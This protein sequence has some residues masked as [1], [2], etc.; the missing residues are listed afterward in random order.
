MRDYYLGELILDKGRFG[1]Y[2][3]Q[4]GFFHAGA[5]YPFDGEE[6]DR[7]EA[8]ALYQGNTCTNPE[9]NQ[10]A[11]GCLLCDHLSFYEVNGKEFVL[12]KEY[13]SNT[14]K[15]RYPGQ[16]VIQDDCTINYTWAQGTVTYCYMLFSGKTYSENNSAAGGCYIVVF[17]W[18]GNH[19]RTLETDREI[20]TFCVDEP[21]RMIYATALDD[22]GEYGIM[23]FKL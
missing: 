3:L 5:T 9:N 20:K 19:V 18:Q 23:Q 17:D 21:N 6:V 16:L 2:N 10:F 22:D 12:L 11:F 13:T 15:A 4:G 14:P 7:M 8:F 1:L